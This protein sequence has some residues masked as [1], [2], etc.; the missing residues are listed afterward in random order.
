MLNKQQFISN[1][2]IKYPSY[3]NLDDNT[4]YDSIIKK[5]PTYKTQIE[6]DTQIPN[7]V[8]Q[9]EQIKQPSVLQQMG[10]SYLDSTSIWKGINI[11]KWAPEFIQ[12]AYDKTKEIASWWVDRMQKAWEWTVSDFDTAWELDA[13]EAWIRGWAWMLQTVWSPVF[14]LIG[15]IWEEAVKKLPDA[16]KEYVK[17]K[18]VPVIE[19]LQEW[20]GWLSPEQQ[21]ATRN[22]A[23]A[24]ELASYFIWLRWGKSLTQWVTKPKVPITPPKWGVWVKWTVWAVTEIPLPVQNT[25]K[26]IKDL[27]QA[28]KNPDVS[29][30]KPLVK[31]LDTEFKWVVWKKPIIKP[32]VPKKL[33]IKDW[34]DITKSDDL[35]RRWLK[36]SVSWKTTEFAY[37]KVNTDLRKWIEYVSKSKW[38]ADDWVDAMIK[39]S[40]RK[41]EI[42]KTVEN[43]NELVNIKTPINEIEKEVIKFMN[44]E[45]WK[46]FM[47]THPNMEAKMF[48]V[49]DNWKKIYGKE[50]TQKQAQLLKTEINKTLAK[51]DFAKIFQSWDANALANAELSKILWNVID[52]N[53]MSVLWN[54]NRALNLE[55]W[56]V[57]NLEKALVRRMWVFNRNTKWWLWGLL[58]TFNTWDIVMWMATWDM[59]Q[60]WTWLLRKVALTTIK[61]WENPNL[62]IKELFKLH[63]TKK[64]WIQSKIQTMIWKEDKSLIL[65]PKV[66]KTDKKLNL[67]ALKTPKGSN[68]SKTKTNASN[69]AKTIEKP[70][71]QKKP[72]VLWK[73]NKGWYVNPWKVI[74]DVTNS[75][76]T[77]TPKNIVTTA[78]RIAKQLWVEVSKV[79]KIL[80]EYV[81]K[82][83]NELKMKAWDL[84]DDI[85]DKLH[86]RHKF[87]DDSWTPYYHATS[88]K[89]AKSIV[90]WKWFDINKSSKWD[91]I[92]HLV[93]WY[94]AKKPLTEYW[95]TI[96]KIKPKWP[97]N[98]A[99]SKEIDLLRKKYPAITSEISLIEHAKKEWFD[100]L[101]LKWKQIVINNKKFNF[102]SNVWKT[103]K[104]WDDVNFKMWNEVKKWK[105]IWENEYWIQ[106]EWKNWPKIERV[107]RDYDTLMDPLLKNKKYNISSTSIT[108]PETVTNPISN[109]K[110]RW[111]SKYYED[112]PWVAR[113]WM[114]SQWD[115][116]PLKSRKVVK[117]TEPYL[118]EVIAEKIPTSL[119]KDIQKFI[120]ARKPDTWKHYFPT[121]EKL[122]PDVY[123]SKKYWKS[124]ILSIEKELKSAKEWLKYNINDLKWTQRDWWININNVWSKL[125]DITTK[126]KVQ[127]WYNKNKVVQLL[128]DRIKYLEN[129]KS[130]TTTPKGITK[131]KSFN[132]VSTTENA[133]STK[134]TKVYR[135]WDKWDFYSIN[136]KTAEWYWKTKEFTIPENA[137]I[138]EFDSKWAI[139]REIDPKFSMNKL[140]DSLLKTQ[141]DKFGWL[142]LEQRLTLKID[143]KIKAYIKKN[144]LDWIVINDKSWFSDQ[145]WEYILKPWFLDKPTIIKPKVISKPKLLKKSTG[146]V[147]EA[148]NT[149]KLLQEA[150]WE[151]EYIIKYAKTSDD[152]I[153]D[154]QWV[155]VN[156]L[157]HW[158]NKKFDTFDIKKKLTGADSQWSTAQL[159]DWIYFTDD[160][161]EAT[162]YSK[163]ISEI[164]WNTNK[165]IVREDFIVW[166]IMKQ[167]ELQKHIA[168][169]KIKWDM[170]NTDIINQNSINKQIEDLWYI[171]RRQSY[172]YD[173]WNS[174]NGVSWNY[175]IFNTKNIKTKAQLKEIYNKATIS[176]PKV[177]TKPKVIQPKIS[178]PSEEYWWTKLD[179]KIE[180]MVEKDFNSAWW[181]WRSFSDYEAK[182][183]ALSMI[184]PKISKNSIKELRKQLKWK[185]V[186]NKI[187]IYRHWGNSWWEVSYTIRKD[188]Y[189]P[190]QK[191][192]EIKSF[193]VDI[194]DIKYF[195]FEGWEGELVLT[196]FAKLITKPKPIS[197]LKIINKEYDNYVKN[198]FYDDFVDDYDDII[199]YNNY[200]NDLTKKWLSNNERAAVYMYVN[201]NYKEINT[202]LRQ[203]NYGKLDNIKKWVIDT[204]DDFLSKQP[205]Y[206]KE[207]YRWSQMSKENLSKL[208]VWDI[209][210]EKWFLSTSSERK[211]VN[212][213]LE[214]D[215]L[216][217]KSYAMIIKSKTGKDIWQYS[218]IPIEKEV[219]FQPNKKFKITKIVTENKEW[220]WDT[221]V[222]YIKEM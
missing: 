191:S 178:K 77:L 12:W 89:D 53:V 94:V 54:T 168:N 208:K 174:N 6:D 32:I 219:L 102:S 177:I 39:T 115:I 14:W 46:A 190:W 217:N 66:I 55:Y 154:I 211:M 119:E 17:D 68:I 206:T 62:I 204:L 185:I 3:N 80:K 74:E 121:K 34:I 140:H 212:A 108:K 59:K 61:R 182:A 56:A 161:K 201:N 25:P 195:D 156:K 98:V 87:I 123:I 101:E 24:A 44:T 5:Y 200:L 142:S 26:I 38:V 69:K 15:Q 186:D 45:N 82:Y 198:T 81:K 110:P 184:I 76:K 183:E 150:D 51:S 218:T 50:L 72:S 203:W 138:K 145:V 47:A 157:F 43:N 37:K 57:R 85:A 221:L 124:D 194:D 171:W 67:E 210:E 116:R 114:W 213:F 207:V 104:T 92:E 172:S 111:S 197:K 96:V 35:I 88:T 49:M 36:P 21:R 58:D 170:Y 158:T 1:I 13:T 122:A 79:T 143:N 220:W 120:W 112:T 42:W 48:W 149:K 73:N 91:K 169:W 144:N 11:A 160:F 152:F 60:A 95:N 205:N 65:K 176:K 202:A 64:P 141:K 181:K 155:N 151:L 8:E 33:I 20:Y 23:V 199:K 188:L 134:W 103:I 70:T 18:A 10:K 86:I 146:L 196:W 31:W 129:I 97:I 40:A 27:V 163:L 147:E 30:Y 125:N 105:V 16:F 214:K 118:N 126:H 7:Q 128:K 93:S 189:I 132:K 130:S 159:G 9:V 162:W 153:K 90:K 193:K 139:L 2:R 117:K 100:L 175:V 19:D 127:S 179:P 136:K 71:N 106:I 131:P 4:L 78:S 165:W 75:L 84:V 22:L 99:W 52:D 41:K 113:W 222:L 83:W 148:K 133:T 28:V 216:R 63:W 209:L 187:S 167:A 215:T 192:H 107:Y 137:N 180:R 164:E 29:D 166:K 135:W 109:K 173:F